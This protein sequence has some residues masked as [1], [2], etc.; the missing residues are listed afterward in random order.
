MTSHGTDVCERVPRKIPG[1]GALR[2]V[3]QGIDGDEDNDSAVG[4]GAAYIYTRDESGWAQQ[5]YVKA[6]NTDALDHFAD[7]VALSDDGM[8][9]AVGAPGESSSASG[10]D[11]DQQNNSLADAGAVYMYA[12][13][14][15]GWAQQAYIKAQNP[16]GD[17][18]GSSVSLNEDGTMLAVGAHME[19][20]H[21]T[22]ID[23]DETDNSLAQAGAVYVFTRTSLWAQTAYI[24]ASNTDG[25]D[26]FG[27][28]VALSHDGS[29]LAVGAYK[30]D[31]G[32]LG[33]GA[34]QADNS[35]SSAGAVYV[36][37]RAPSG[38]WTQRAY[39][40]APNAG[41]FDLF[42]IG[43]ALS[44]DGSTL[45]VGARGEL[46]SATGIGGDQADNSI[47]GAGAVYLY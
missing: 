9:L 42:G 19:A 36:Y 39:V 22:G 5:A 10:I 32:G 12:R 1:G 41:A 46:S 18:F 27:S 35:L 6:S 13:D 2:E 14:D 4:S 3:W 16:G 33:L 44:D 38:V 11:G 25:L 29:L 34:D 20:S 30:E 37:A 43:L 23:G 26:H 24:K 15:V 8:L 47:N 21:A 7:S 31:S 40:K 45:A 28:S 17:F